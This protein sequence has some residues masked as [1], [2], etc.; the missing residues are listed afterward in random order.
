M[1]N[2]TKTI[3]MRKNQGAAGE[4]I[5]I[6]V[7]DDGQITIRRAKQSTN[8]RWKA[9][10]FPVSIVGPD[11]DRFLKEKINAFRID[12]FEQTSTHSLKSLAIVFQP[13]E[14]WTEDE[15]F[16]KALPLCNDIRTVSTMGTLGTAYVSRGFGSGGMLEY[17]PSFDKVPSMLV[18]FAIG[19]DVPIAAAMFLAIKRPGDLKATWSDGIEQPLPKLVQVADLPSSLRDY[20]VANDCIP[21]PL[22]F[23]QL[24]GASSPSASLSMAL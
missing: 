18:A 10:T 12:G 11:I 13:S 20:L 8:P 16:E 23:Q 9:S 6:Q 4:L 21:K 5:E 7:M 15:A 1:A 17:R 19:N 2:I 14:D 22:N 3:R 24:R